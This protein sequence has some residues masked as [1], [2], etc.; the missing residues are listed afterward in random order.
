MHVMDDVCESD[1]CVWRV[2]LATLLTS[3]FQPCA[4]R[5]GVPVSG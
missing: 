5:H 1:T 3:A 4:S 2:L